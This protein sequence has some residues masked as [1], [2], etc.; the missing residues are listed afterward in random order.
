MRAERVAGAAIAL[1]VVALLLALIWYGLAVR[2]AT[3][4]ADGLALFEIPP[5]APPPPETPP[6]PVRT[7]SD[8]EQGAAAPPGRRADPAPV[9]APV[10]LVQPTPPP[11]TAPPV[12]AE[13]S[14]DNAGATDRDS[15]GTGAGGEGEGLG[16][17]GS[18]TGRGS[19]IVS[20]ARRV[21]GAI[22]PRDYPRE[23]ARAGI[24]GRVV[25][26]LSVDAR[27]R[28]TDCRVALSS[29]SPLLDGATC[30]LARERFRY[31]PARDTAGKPVP[32][33]AGYRQDW[34]LDPR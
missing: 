5:E 11:E 29:G 6:E 3:S 27:G 8:A 31:E 34:W 32:D 26:T 17:G 9:A 13:G 25:V 19:G 15:P 10:P 16:S 1:A 30:R 21:R 4:A 7:P 14:A 23:A 24:T 28:V 22:T 33:L 18:G 2:V 12:P 20:P